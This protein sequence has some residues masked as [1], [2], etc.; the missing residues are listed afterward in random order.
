MEFDLK[1]IANLLQGK[2]EGEEDVKINN[3]ATIQDAKEG[4][5]TFLSNPKYEPFIYETNASAVIIGKDIVLKRQVK[6][7]L[8]R[9]EDPYLSFTA[10]L[11]EYEKLLSFS[12]DGIEEPSFI[13]KDVTYGDNFYLGAFSYIANNVVIG[14][15]VKVHPQVFVGEGSRI[16]ENTIIHAGVKIYP[17]TEIGKNCIIHSGAVLGSDGF[18][19][20]PKSDGSYQ[21]IPQVGK[22]IIEDDV[23]I[24]ANTTIDRATFEATII[25]KGVKIDNLIQ[26]AHN[27]EIGEN[28]VMAAQ[29]GV[30][31]SV[32]IGKE[33]IVAGQVG[34]SGHLQIANKVKIGPQAGLISSIKKEG[35]EIVGSPPIDKLQYFK[36]Y[37]VYRKLPELVNRVK[38]LEDKIKELDPTKESHE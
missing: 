19:F 13:G 36:S 23:E 24:G 33:C 10:L 32:K 14:D 11:Q 9:V 16:H 2:I 25:R 4:C 26:I 7:S 18:G 8:V 15:N 20:A 28:T 21:K 6:T 35:A 22:L 3:L 37:A 12:K 1:E 30:S 38:E 34:I 17:N 31:G 27:V 29:S 5:I